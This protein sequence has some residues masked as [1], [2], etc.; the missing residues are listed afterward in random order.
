MDIVKQYEELLKLDPGSIAFVPLAEELCYRGF[1][2]GALKVCRQG[3]THHPQH[4]RGR[5]LL[6]WA[7]KELGEHEE[8]EEVLRGVEGEIQ[9]N[10]L[11]FR[12][13][14]EL[15]K[16][17]GAS[18]RAERLLLI[19]QNLQPGLMERGFG[20][21]AK[22]EPALSAEPPPA[23]PPGPAAEPSAEPPPAAP[24]AAFQAEPPVELP[25]EL[26]AEPPAVPLAAAQPIPPEEPPLA[27]P[28]AF[29]AEPLMEPPI[30]PAVLP[31][32]APE[33]AAPEEAE[34][35]SPA[36]EEPPAAE[37]PPMSPKEEVAGFLSSLLDRYEA[38]PEKSAAEQQ[39]FS[40]DDR[41]TL[42]RI[43]KSLRP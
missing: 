6:G 5:V 42:S 11:L 8:A 36:P 2:E 3:L 30:E 13:L 41:R 19:H 38:L 10:A 7:L 21:V 22:V 33:A 9:K 4:L 1:W 32:A 29:Q 24:P 12:L 31:S 43:L 20:G 15:A 23:P 39:L 25:I 27:P 34:F 17:G 40:E 35:Q 18:E 16:K 28:A 26:A 37:P 14:A